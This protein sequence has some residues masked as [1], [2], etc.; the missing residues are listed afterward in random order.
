M[1]ILIEVQTGVPPTATDVAILG[2]IR[3]GETLT[4]I[5][6]AVY[7]SPKGISRNCLY[8]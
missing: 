6:D 2:N 4:G 5:F 8:Y 7:G 1:M 3:V